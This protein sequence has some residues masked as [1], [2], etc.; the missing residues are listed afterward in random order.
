MDKSDIFFI[1]IIAGL[2]Y[3]YLTK[4]NQVNI[5]ETINSKLDENLNSIVIINE[6]E[7]ELTLFEQIFNSIQN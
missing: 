2:S 5:K 4:P 6:S 1:I 7:I 3:L